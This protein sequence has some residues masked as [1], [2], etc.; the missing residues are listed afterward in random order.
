MIVGAPGIC[1]GINCA[2]R[3]DILS[4]VP[5]GLN[6]QMMV[7]VLPLKNVSAALEDI[8]P[9]PKVTA[10]TTRTKNRNPLTIT[11]SFHRLTLSANI[12]ETLT[13]LDFRAEGGSLSFVIC[14]FT[15][16]QK[17][18][19]PLTK[20][21]K[22]SLALSVLSG[23]TLPVSLTKAVGGYLS[24]QTPVVDASSPLK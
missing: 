19:R 22:E 23:R 13:P 14:Q 17:A 4:Y 8:A 2:V 9:L 21:R 10:V 16:K 20:N 6:G 12:N 11:L 1:F 7:M 18:R 3:R 5:P 15:N 24:I